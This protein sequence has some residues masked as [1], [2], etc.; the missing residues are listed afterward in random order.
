MCYYRLGVI[1]WRSRSPLPQIP[2]RHTVQGRIV[3]KSMTTCVN[4]TDSMFELSLPLQ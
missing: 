1:S 4:L 3:G 2:P